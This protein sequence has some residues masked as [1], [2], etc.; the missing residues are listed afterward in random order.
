LWYV[1]MLVPVIGLVQV[2][3]QAMA[4]RYTYLPQIGLCLCL[5]WGA[6]TLC[7]G[8]PRL[9]PACGAAAVAAATALGVCA[10]RQTVY[11]R[12]SESLW[13]RTLACT[14]KNP[15]AHIDM[16]I[17]LA[18]TGRLDAAVEHFREGLKLR[19]DAI[20][21][22][23][24]LAT[25]LR[26]VGKLDEAIGQY[27][28]VLK[29]RPDEPR[30]RLAL[31]RALAVR[32]GFDD[33]IAEYRNILALRPNDPVAQNDLAWLRATCPSESRRNGE[34]AVELARR[35]LQHGTEPDPGFLDTLAAAYAE[36][37]RFPDALQTARSA[38]NLAE[39]QG[40]ERLAA[41]IRARLA[42]YEA[43]KPFRD[44]PP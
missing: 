12:N 43:G 22:R 32:K 37:G 13:T 26:G 23:Y 11:W 29:A 10:W 16:G 25:A 35:A 24:N 42:M 34:E 5:A 38:L 18:C 28:W 44:S 31:D 40:K 2:G 30:S 1:G 20:E 27:Q 6:A 39:R 21:A 33:A 15:T 3:S 41:G 7:R 9:A 8:R 36:V 14:S 19:P 4:D 17:I